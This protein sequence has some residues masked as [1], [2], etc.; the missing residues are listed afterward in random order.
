MLIVRI[1]ARKR[2]RKLY[3]FSDIW[4]VRIHVWRTRI[5]QEF[6]EYLFE[7][8]FNED[9]RKRATKKREEVISV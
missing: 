2:K 8:G 1:G 3:K 4:G 6:R 9:T 5:R 7:N